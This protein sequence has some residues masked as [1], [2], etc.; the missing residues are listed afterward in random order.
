MYSVSTALASV[1]GLQHTD[2][3][4]PR[5]AKLFSVRGKEDS[6]TMIHIFRTET[7]AHSMGTPSDPLKK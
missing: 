3:F 6:P 4:L 2:S 1:A 5:C 7:E